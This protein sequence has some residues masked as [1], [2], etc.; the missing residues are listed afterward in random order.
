MLRD[1]LGNTRVVFRPGSGTSLSV[2]ATHAYYPFGMENT[3]IGTGA[4]G[5]D[6]K[7]NGKE[8]DASL[9]LYDYGARWYDPAVARWLAVDPLAESMSN[10]SPYNYTFNNPINFTD[11][12]GMAPDGDYY[13]TDGTWIKSDG[14]DDD[15][16]YVEV[17]LTTAGE[18]GISV[19]HTG[20]VEIA[21]GNTTLL[22]LASTSY[23]ESSER[24]NDADE[25]S[26]IS[27]AIVN[28]SMASGDDIPTTIDGF[29]FAA[30]DG[31]ARVAE[32][33]STS[34]SGRNGTSM[35]DAIAGAIN[36]LSGGEDLS[37][38]ATH[39]AGRDIGSSAEKR[40]TGG[41]LFTDTSHDLHNLGS[42]TAPR[43]PVTTHW[44]D[45][46]GRATGERGSYSYTW[47]TTAAHG[48]STFM[49]KTAAFLN[50]TGAPRH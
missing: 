49:K 48:E 17:M 30:S 37:N 11:P 28:N 14:V 24:L 10:W 46:N 40:A 33:N 47:E 38:G 12:D 20:F 18:S 22:N 2:L 3:A 16:A 45:S 43:A 41:L 34:S 44:K 19:F 35:Q 21:E 39:W 26:A 50:A 25:M 31:N 4:S 15:K 42:K 23:G 32:F 6:Y 8:L 1:H 13:K 36:A 5:Y 9:G 29:A 7:Y 27:S